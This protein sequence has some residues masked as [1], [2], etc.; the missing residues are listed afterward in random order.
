MLVLRRG[1]YDGAERDVVGMWYN[2]SIFDN[3]KKVVVYMPTE[4]GFITNS[5]VT[6]Y[7]E[8]IQIFKL[9]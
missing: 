8:K 3:V 6:T 5:Q 1:T 2:Y 7:I 4:V 9:G